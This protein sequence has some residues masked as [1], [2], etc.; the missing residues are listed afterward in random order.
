MGSWL[1]HDGV[2]PICFRAYNPW[3]FDCLEA[4]RADDSSLDFIP[5]YLVG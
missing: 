3:I 5:K 2:R 4:V 1:E